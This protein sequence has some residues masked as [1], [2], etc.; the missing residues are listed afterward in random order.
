ME[1]QRYVQG[2]GASGDDV[3]SLLPLAAQSG[4]KWLRG[5]L[6]AAVI[7]A[8]AIASVMAFSHQ[9]LRGEPVDLIATHA[10]Q[11]ASSIKP[12]KPRKVCA[13]GKEGCMD[14]GCC[15]QSGA[16]CFKKDEKH[17]WCNMTCS[18]G[19]GWSC[20]DITATKA[21][22][23]A[24]SPGTTLYCYAVHF[25][26]NHGKPNHEQE[27]LKMQMQRGLSIF[28]CDA[29]DVFSDVQLTLG[30]YEAVTVEDVEGD[31]CKYERPDTGACANTAIF[32]KVWQLMR[33]TTAV[34]SK[35]QDKSWVIKADADAVLIPQ[36][37]T[38]MLSQ[39]V[40]PSNGVYYENCKGVD[41]GFYGNLEVVSTKGFKIA[42][43]N[44][45]DCKFNLCW[46]GEL[47]QEWEWG[48]WGED[49]FLQECMDR[50]GVAKMPLFE[51]TYDGCCASDRP[52]GVE[53]LPDSKNKPLK[54]KPNCLDS[55]APSTHP[56]KTVELWEACYADTMK[57]SLP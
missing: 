44:M 16:R 14:S 29:Y 51:L 42:I 46:G 27:L 53:T 17:A 28:A 10:T 8:V 48:P 13:S 41:S 52:E 43:R 47:C 33:D 24:E 15:K 45:E 50:H 9:K 39:Q 56:F 35:L 23:A 6:G 55:Y 20:E 22:I 54:W 57:L 26:H 38:D 19:Q 25:H 31:F 21:E 36:R 49:K 37:L 34:S 3:Q 11:M 40:E 12:L 30:D 1:Q 7:V 18:N 4:K 5:A 32:Y 2:E